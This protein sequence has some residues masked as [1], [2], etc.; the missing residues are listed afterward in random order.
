MKL[1]LESAK[2]GTKVR[3]MV[4]RDTPM[5]FARKI[6]GGFLVDVLQDYVINIRLLGLNGLYLFL[7]YSKQSRNRFEKKES[8]AMQVLFRA[9]HEFRVR[10]LG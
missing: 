3:T 2:A 1:V 5:H 4:K 7:V 10:K 9:S 6:I 8:K